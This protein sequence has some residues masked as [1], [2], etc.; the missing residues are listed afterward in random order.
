[1]KNKLIYCARHNKKHLICT[2]LASVFFAFG[3]FPLFFNIKAI[4]RF[5]N[6]QSE[7]LFIS[8]TALII[9]L[10]ILSSRKVN[11]IFKRYRNTS[12]LEYPP[13]VYIDFIGFFIICV[14]LLITIF[15]MKVIPERSCQFNLFFIINIIFTL[16]WLLVS[17]IW[18]KKNEGSETQPIDNYSL[19]DDPIQYPIQDT[20]GREQFVD[21]LYA[22]IINLPFDDSFVFGLHGSWGEGKTSVLNL[23][24][25]KIE[26]NQNFLLVNFDPW[27]FKNEEAIIAAFYN[28][29][30]QVISSQ[31]IFHDLKKTFLRYQKLI[32]SG[33]SQTGLTFDFSDYNETIEDSRQKIE[34]YITAIKKKIVIFI[35]DLDRLQPEEILLIFKIVRINAKFKNTIFILSFDENYVTD[36]LEERWTTSGRWSND[37]VSLIHTKTP[38][39]L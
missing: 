1:M 20:L 16:L 31:F 17:C 18:N 14:T 10:L 6:S 37:F 4:E 24:K 22:E 13:L 32:S 29:I 19:S 38:N 9:L 27:Y 28:Q 8:I 21:D 15:Q 11:Y 34:S 35:D 33:L 30:E 26:Q 36:I 2:L 5:L 23:L 3:I 39:A 25:I 12:N 7:K